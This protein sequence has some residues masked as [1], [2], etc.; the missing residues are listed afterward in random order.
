MAQFVVDV[1]IHGVLLF[2]VKMGE[3]S[4]PPAAR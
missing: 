2:K 4:K 1:V 3:K